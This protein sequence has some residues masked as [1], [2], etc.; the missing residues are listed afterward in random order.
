MDLLGIHRRDQLARQGGEDG[1]GI[2]GRLG[3]QG[4]TAHPPSTGARSGAC[5][6]P[7]TDAIPIRPI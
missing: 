5:S 4:Q 6:P 3:Q 1:V 7:F 2:L